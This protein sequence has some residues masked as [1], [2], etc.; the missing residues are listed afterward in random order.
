[1]SVTTTGAC[2]K[3]EENEEQEKEA[4]AAAAGSLTGAL[5]AE[6]GSDTDSDF[7]LETE[8][9]PGQGLPGRSPAVVE[10]TG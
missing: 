8:G 3:S 1:M 6:E 2:G 9:A 7:Y 5:E 10:G 4:V